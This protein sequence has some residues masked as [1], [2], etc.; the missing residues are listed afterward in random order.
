M[1]FLG[2]EF[3]SNDRERLRH[4]VRPG[5]TGYAQVH[6][7]NAISWEQKFEYDI[8]YVEHLN[9]FTD[10]KIVIDTVKAVFKSEGIALN[11]LEDFDEYR[12][13]SNSDTEAG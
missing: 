4:T 2:V 10:V 11:A 5:L 6:G 7:R 9:F 1:S 8:Y 3:Y 12:K 13:H